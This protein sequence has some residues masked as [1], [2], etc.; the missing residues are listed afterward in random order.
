MSTR[1]HLYDLRPSR[2]SAPSTSSHTSATSNQDDWHN[3]NDI[4]FSQSLLKKFQ[5][6]L[7]NSVPLKPFSMKFEH[8]GDIQ[9]TQAIDVKISYGCHCI[10]I[11]Q[12]H[13]LTV[14]DLSS[15]QLIA[16]SG[17]RSCENILVENNYNLETKTGRDALILASNNVT[18]HPLQK[19]YLKNFIDT[20]MK[21]PSDEKFEI[22]RM[23]IENNNQSNS[24]NIIYSVCINWIAIW[25]VQWPTNRRNYYGQLPWN[26]I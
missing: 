8:V 10:L 24:N 4:E 21:N 6:K 15:K 3:S 26:N 22:A 23:C 13:F 7:R 18:A 25:N 12:Y 17:E 9:T 5:H 20:L 19:V 11:S 14:F 2:S 16:K 1:I